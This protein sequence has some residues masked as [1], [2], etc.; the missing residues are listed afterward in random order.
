MEEFEKKQIEKCRKIVNWLRATNNFG[1]AKIIEN[2]I[3]IAEL[4]EC[5]PIE[6][7]TAEELDDAVARVIEEPTIEASQPVV[8]E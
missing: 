7:T 5:K 4:A 1:S 2:V 3:A 8:N 6:E